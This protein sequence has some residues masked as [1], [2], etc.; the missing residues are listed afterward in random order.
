MPRENSFTDSEGR[1]LT[2]EPERGALSPVSALRRPSKKLQRSNAPPTLRTVTW[3]NLTPK[4]KFRASVHKVIALY[5]ANGLSM[6][7][8]NGMYVGAEP[9]VDPRRLA[10]EATYGHMIHPCRIEIVDYSAIRNTH[11]VMSKAEFVDLMDT[12]SSEPPPKP[13][14]AKVRWINIC[15]LSWDV[16]KAVSIAYGALFFLLYIDR[17]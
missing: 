7:M 15:G 10:A 5:R 11:C 13:P 9:G 6:L 12:G 4:E 17:L 3:Q 1:S 8:A 2:P 14:W 16:I